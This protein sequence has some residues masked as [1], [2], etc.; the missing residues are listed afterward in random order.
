MKKNILWVSELIIA[1]LLIV[2]SLFS[3]QVYYQN[4]IEDKVANLKEVAAAFDQTEYT[5]DNTGAGLFSQ[6]AF[7]AR[8]TIFNEQGDVL[9]ESEGENFEN[10]GSREEFQ[11]AKQKGEGYA[12]RLSKTTEKTTLYYCKKI[13]GG[14]LRLA[15]PAT[16]FWLAFVRTLPTIGWFLLLSLL[17]SL[18]IAYFETEYI[19]SPVRKIAKQAALSKRVESKYAE[20]KPIVDILNKRN[21]E[22]ESQVKRILE[23]KEIALRAKRSKDDFIANVTHE[24]NTPLTSIRGY[25]ELLASGTLNERQTKDAAD[26]L[27]KQS[28]R[29]SALIARIINYSEL[30]SDELPSYEVDASLLLNDL[31]KSLEPSILEKNICLKTEIED[32]VL[33]MSRHERVGELFG[34]LIRN[35][36]R[37]NAEGGE[38]FV[39]LTKKEGSFEFQVADTGVG[40]AEEDLERIFDRFYTVDKSH[41]GKGGGFGLGLAVVK[42]LCNKSN[43]RITVES[44]LGQGTKFTV[45]FPDKK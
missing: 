11:A 4:G 36:I 44:K 31:L 28:E 43:W 2:F 32:G 33:L 24:M 39:S 16:S 1:L 41:S 15:V 7:G 21:E 9:G 13:D 38:L 19:I 10:H 6:R 20:L 14:Y 8:V 30:D 5:L 34:N 12:V 25:S 40:I 17:I 29:L 22:I 23:E 3:S 18:M 37:Y 35:A 26:V 45:V 42:K 27:L